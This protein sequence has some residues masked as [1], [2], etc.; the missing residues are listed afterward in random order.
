MAGKMRL[1]EHTDFDQIVVATQNHFALPRLTNQI[2]EKDYYVT[3]ALRII[4]QH[5][6]CEIIFKGGTSLSK[7]WNLIQRFSEDIDLYVK[8]DGLGKS[9]IDRKLKQ[10]RDAITA[11]PGLQFLPDESSTIGGFGRCDRFGYS[12][13]FTEINSIAPHVFLEVGTNSGIY[14]TETRPISSYVAEFLRTTGVSLNAE[15]EAPFDMPLLHYRR[16]FVEKMFA[17]HAKVEIFKETGTPIGGYAR[18]FYDL[19]CLAQQPD[20]PTMLQSDE[21]ADIKADYER[22]SLASF[23]RGYRQPADMS[24]ANSDALFPASDLD[25]IL[26]VEYERQCQALCFADYPRW[27]EVLSTFEQLREAL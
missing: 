3:E 23:P 4:A 20:V 24:F 16:T 7:G 25:N 1:F 12:P 21:Y 22:I 6:P 15:D 5:L 14:P 9:A 2:I 8:P 17:I 19:W 26:F 27:S 18:H 11:H 10:L 13:S